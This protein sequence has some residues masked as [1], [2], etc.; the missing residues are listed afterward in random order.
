[1]IKNGKDYPAII[2][3]PN[4]SDDKIQNNSNNNLNYFSWVLKQLYPQHNNNML[5][6]YE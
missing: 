1:M 3:F 6:Y 5:Y 4:C 2:L